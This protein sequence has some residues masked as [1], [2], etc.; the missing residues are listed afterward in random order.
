MAS[1]L[2]AQQVQRPQTLDPAGTWL[3]MGKKAHIT[4]G[5]EWGAEA[6]VLR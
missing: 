1:L 2:E 6:G 5:G 4:L 3:S